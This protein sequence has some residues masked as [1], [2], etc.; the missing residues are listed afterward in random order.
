MPQP[1]PD[2]AG[3]EGVPQLHDEDKPEKLDRD[4]WGGQVSVVLWGRKI[5][6]RYCLILEQIDDQN[7][8]CSTRSKPSEG[9]ARFWIGPNAGCLTLGVPYTIL[10][11]LCCFVSRF[12]LRAYRLREPVLLQHRYVVSAFGVRYIAVASG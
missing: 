2:A 6:E 11:H 4:L 10:H 5:S 3:E 7:F 12:I 9:H 1:W 8:A